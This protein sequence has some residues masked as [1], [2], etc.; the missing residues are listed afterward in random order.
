[1][2]TDHVDWQAVCKDLVELMMLQRQASLMQ[3]DIYERYLI[4]LKELKGPR[5][6]ELRKERKQQP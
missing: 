1:V 2:S 5:T 6:S 4:K 3:V